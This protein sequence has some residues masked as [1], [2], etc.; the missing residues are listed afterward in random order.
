[1]GADYSFV[2]KN[3]KIWAP[4]F[5]KHN[6]SFVATVSNMF[7]ASSENLNFMDDNINCLKNGCKEQDRKKGRFPFM[8]L[9]SMALKNAK[10]ENGSQ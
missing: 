2:V 1:M 3:I 5:F 7:V 9:K 10:K 4:A 8:Y 6:N